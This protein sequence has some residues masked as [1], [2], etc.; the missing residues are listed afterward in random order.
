LA[1][2]EQSPSAEQADQSVPAIQGV[3]SSD[4]ST[5]LSLV[6]SRLRSKLILSKKGDDNLQFFSSFE[7]A[8]PFASEYPTRRSGVEKAVPGELRAQIH[9]RDRT[10]LRINTL[11][12]WSLRR[13]APM[14]PYQI[15]FFGGDG[16]ASPKW[17]IRQGVY[18]R[19]GNML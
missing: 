1:F 18:S 9:A 11:S 14:A 8:A 7:P 5:E 13:G 3:T 2:A 19:G 10:D 17:P 15:I 12:D 6:R 4:E 16:G